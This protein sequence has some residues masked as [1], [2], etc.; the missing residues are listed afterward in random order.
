M[1]RRR[2]LK[3]GASACAVPLVSGRLSAVY[4]M[5]PLAGLAA[6]AGNDRILV[7]IR[8]DGGNDGLNTVL[9]LD[10]YAN[11]SKARA[12]ILIPEA[13][14]AKLT[15]ATGLHPALSGL[16]NLYADGKLRVIQ[17]VG[18]P[19][20]NQ[21]HF[22]STDIWFSASD[23]NQVLATGWLG[24][25]LEGVYPGYPDGYPSKDFPDPPAVQIGSSLF[26]LLQGFSVPMGMAV[27][28]ATSIYSLVPAGYDTAPATPAGHEL[29]F[30]RQMF[31]E[32]QKYGEALKKAVAAAANKSS[33]Y[34]ATGNALSDQLK[35]VARL[36]AG[37]LQTKVYVLSLH[38]FDTHANQVLA[39][40]TAA[41]SHAALLAKLNDAIVA[42]QDDLRLLG[43]EQRVLGITMSEFGRRI[44]SNASLG[45]DHG[46]SAPMFVWGAGVSGGLS[47]TNPA[48]P[49]TVTVKD[50]IPM[51]FDYRS[52]YASILTDWLGVSGDDLRKVLLKDF[53]ALP[54][55]ASPVLPHA[56]K[57]AGP[58]LEQN[59]P[60][61]F[62]GATTLRYRVAS[63]GERVRLRV[64]DAR[65]ILVRVV[66][67]G[68]HAPGT[69]AR[70]LE[71]GTLSPGTYFCRLEAGGRTTQRSM[72]IM[73]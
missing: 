4:G 15:E 35:G 8:L 59:F 43:L 14:A 51:Q 54:I 67:D 58:E 32:T 57:A 68:F 62:R 21:S 63:G 16:A 72:E 19:N 30:I 70:T 23:Y 11:L 17:S 47:G 1:D 24:R 31:T 37:G 41:G 13:Q 73:R 10:Q 46:T 12:N 7:V 34:P 25:Y 36:I 27:A 5:S 33:L 50:N 69:Y 65:G 45:T 9:P 44:L 52:V 28:N 56:G 64:F 26:T 66:A 55:V 20:H 49:D 42:F 39:A 53:P 3:L 38:G 18:Y 48:I 60:N 6:M 29:T 22:R 61:P 71:A 2:F 40:D